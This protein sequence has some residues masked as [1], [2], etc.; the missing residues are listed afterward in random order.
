METT[1]KKLEDKNLE[2]YIIIQKD[3]LYTKRNDRERS[4]G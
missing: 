2:M 1:Y 4:L 3:K